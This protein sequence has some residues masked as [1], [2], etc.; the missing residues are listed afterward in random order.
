MRAIQLQ[1]PECRHTTS[2]ETSCDGM[3]FDVGE[4]KHVLLKM[5]DHSYSIL[6]WR[7][8]AMRCT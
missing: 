5:R 4:L 6:A 2:L 8:T 1:F 3:K 7:L